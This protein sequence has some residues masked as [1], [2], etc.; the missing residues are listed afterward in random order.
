LGLLILLFPI[1]Q[2]MSQKSPDNLLRDLR[3]IQARNAVGELTYADIFGS[4]YYSDEFI[5]SIVYLKDG[6]HAT[7]PIRYDLFKDEIEF[8]RDNALLW[9]EKKD[10]AYISMGKETLIVEP[11]SDAP[12][13]SAYFFVQDTGKYSLFIRRKARFEAYVPPRAYVEAVPDRFKREN[14]LF[15]LKSEGLPA[16]EINSKKVLQTILNDNPQALEFIKRTRVRVN[17]S[18]DLHALVNFLNN[19]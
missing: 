8:K 15:F 11:A 12:G 9:L 5:N 19:Q 13:K 4:P 18:E 16:L 10:V 1:N 17:K 2:L 7:L 3:I 6:E 14:D